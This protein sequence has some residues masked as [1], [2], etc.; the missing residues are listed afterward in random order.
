M[1]CI[2]KR[3]RFRVYSD[4]KLIYETRDKLMIVRRKTIIFS[5]SIGWESYRL[6]QEQIFI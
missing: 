5:G 1:F 4:Y 2:S 3:A 6:K